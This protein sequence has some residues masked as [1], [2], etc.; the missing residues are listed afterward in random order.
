MVGSFKHK[1]V[2]FYV[3]WG[4]CILTSAIRRDPVQMERLVCVVSGKT[5]TSWILVTC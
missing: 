5:R 4:V 3:Q 1:T 2:G